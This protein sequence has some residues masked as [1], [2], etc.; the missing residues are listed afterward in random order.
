[1]NLYL[2]ITLPV[3]LQVL[4]WP[5]DNVIAKAPYESTLNCS[6]QLVLQKE[7]ALGKRT[8]MCFALLCQQP[9]M[10]QN[11]RVSPETVKLS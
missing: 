2:V 8:E 1:M 4:P 11:S 5:I 6:W 3:L 9:V 7:G 10:V